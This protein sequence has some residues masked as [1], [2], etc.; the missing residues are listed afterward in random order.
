[1]LQ[2]MVTV[3]DAQAARIIQQ[4]DGL[5][6]F[7]FEWGGGRNPRHYG[8]VRVRDWSLGRGRGAGYSDPEHCLRIHCDGVGASGGKTFY[9][10]LHKDRGRLHE[11]DKIT[12]HIAADAQA[13]TTR[14]TKSMEGV[15]RKRDD[16]AASKS[17][18]TSQSPEEKRRLLSGMIRL[19][20][21]ET[22]RLIQ[23]LDGLVGFDFDYPAGKRNPT[24]KHATVVGWGVGP[25]GQPGYSADRSYIHIDCSGDEQKTFLGWLERIREGHP[26][27]TVLIMNLSGR[28]NALGGKINSDL[29]DV[30]KSPEE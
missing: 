20:D 26:T 30:L 3:S 25:G 17:A 2:Q 4:L 6:G 12:S 27:R 23:C 21:T 7:D 15:L 22:D 8:H 19:E 5:V 9:G 1:M 14:I 29:K 11:E 10:S 18:S 13:L 28:T 16:T 24:T